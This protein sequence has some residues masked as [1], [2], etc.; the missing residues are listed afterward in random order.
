MT[1]VNPPATT[2]GTSAPVNGNSGGSGDPT[3][4]KANGG[5][6][7]E[8]QV[9][10]VLLA[11]TDQG[12]YWMNGLHGAWQQAPAFGSSTIYDLA[13]A[14]RGSEFFVVV[15]TS[16]GVQQIRAADGIATPIAGSIPTIALSKR[17]S[18]VFCATAKG[19]YA[20][21]VGTAPT[22]ATPVGTFNQPASDVVATSSAVFAAT[23]TGIVEYRNGAFSSLPRSINRGDAITPPPVT[24]SDEL[25]LVDTCA[26]LDATDVNNPVLLA[27]SASTGYANDDVT[28]FGAAPTGSVPGPFGVWPRQ[29]VSENTEALSIDLAS[30]SVDVKPGDTVLVSAHGVPTR[31]FTVAGVATISRTDYGSTAKVTRLTFTGARGNVLPP[32]QYP[33]SGVTV[34]LLSE[35]TVRGA[36]SLQMSPAS[37]GAAVLAPTTRLVSA[38]TASGAPSDRANAI[39]RAQQSIAGIPVYGRG[40]SSPRSVAPVVGKT[41]NAFPPARP[42]VVLGAGS[43]VRGDRIALIADVALPAGRTVAVT[44]IRC[45]AQLADTG[46]L[47]LIS[48]GDD[49]PKRILPGWDVESLAAVGPRI[50]VATRQGPVFACRFSP[51]PSTATGVTGSQKLTATASN[52]SIELIVDGSAGPLGAVVGIGA[53]TLLSGTRN[54]RIYRY[55]L[56]SFMAIRATNSC[57]SGHLVATIPDSP[58]VTALL[59]LD[60]SGVPPGACTDP[61]PALLIG[62]SHGAFLVPEG[63]EGED[64][65]FDGLTPSVHALA[66]LG[67]GRYLAATSDGIWIRTSAESRWA[68]YGDRLKGIDTVGVVVSA[69][70]LRAVTRDRGVFASDGGTAWV[71]AV[72]PSGADFTCIAVDVEGSAIVG[73]DGA[74]LLQLR[75]HA[76]RWMTRPVGISNGV[77]CAV[78]FGTTVAVGSSRT[79]TMSDRRGDRHRIA[80]ADIGHIEL[81][82]LSPDAAVDA[83]VVGAAALA[84]SETVNEIVDALDAGVILNPLAHAL[85]LA[86]LTVPVRVNIVTVIPRTRWSIDSEALRATFTRS[87]S[88]LTIS[89]PITSMIVSRA[90][91]AD[92]LGSAEWSLQSANSTV[93]ISAFPDELSLI[94]GQPHDDAVAEIATLA[95]FQSHATGTALA[96][97]Q[98]PLRSAFDAR[99]V[100]VSANVVDVT[101]GES[102]GS[103]VLGSARQTP[104]QR[105]SLQKNPLTYLAGSAGDGL[106]STLSVWIGQRRT[107][108]FLQDHSPGTTIGQPGESPWRCVPTLLDAGPAD[109]VYMLDHSGGT[110]AVIFGDGRHGATLPAGVDN[111]VA[112]YRTGVG[113]PVLNPGALTVLRSPPVGVRS[114][115]NP[116]ATVAGDAA[117]SMSD[118]KHRIPMH[119]RTATRI[120]TQDDYLSFAL[121]FSGIGRAQLDSVFNGTRRWLRI[122]VGD[123]HGAPIPPESPLLSALHSAIAG[124]RTGSREFDVA[125][126]SVGW[127][128]IDVEVTPFPDGDDIALRTAVAKALNDSFG[129]GALAVGQPVDLL[130]VELTIASVAG[131]AASNVRSLHASGD[132]AV[133]LN[134]IHADPLRWDEA[135]RTVV[136]PVM[137]ALSKSV[138]SIAGMVV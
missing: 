91:A 106:V 28:P 118:L 10:T 108:P 29:R 67:D 37:H 31:A 78:A 54:G 102:V 99:T 107:S 43:T 137:L 111:I 61:L 51:R 76:N 62:T 66:S 117:E 138:I 5:S 71:L 57:D 115:L 14:R 69:D 49:Y 70:G 15:A 72:P 109:H 105:Y 89:T 63:Q 32:D 48:D 35:G 96:T 68:R 101:Q 1:P 119:V 83:P 93:F 24:S 82:S 88:D 94:P 127:F 132:R 136:P 2:P 97:L 3:Q 18:T 85:S 134:T 129:L 104:F 100:T 121:A 87:G 9:G 52:P 41:P 36:A 13:V 120:V 103:D 25:A 122:T 98:E 45:R 16:E 92:A 33:I 65:I 21:E 23:E 58:R 38:S 4:V 7:S 131:V 47:S 80:P 86:G 20:F 44:G 130:E 75:K 73:S 90:P 95:S 135:T 42:P 59:P 50:V 113:A 30:A 110:T 11:G 81:T 26:V 17:D 34:H 116:V 55:S 19:I 125:S 56:G 60:S 112:T 53:E 133:V 12:L 39:G 74:D 114:V 8:P 6:S 126:Y 77:T 128:D 27:I 64:A 84:A 40:R 123:S 79:I 22:D 46:G 124:S